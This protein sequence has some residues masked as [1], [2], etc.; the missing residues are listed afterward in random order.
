MKPG[1]K[2]KPTHLKLIEGN[3]GKRPLNS[4]EART[5]PSLPAA[6]PHLTADALEEWNRV[7]DQL[8]RIG[9]LS[10]VDR[11]ALAAYAQAYGRWV[12]AERAIAKMAEKDQLTGGLMIKT[13]NGN[14]WRL[15]ESGF[16]KVSGPE[17]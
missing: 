2:P 16:T 13:S 4:K 5:I 11:A 7:A 6:P 10:E 14:L 17:A 12:Q 15:N 8:H 9:L 1:T 3:R